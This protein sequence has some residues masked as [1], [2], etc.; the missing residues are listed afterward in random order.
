MTGQGVV[1]PRLYAFSVFA[2]GN[3]AKSFEYPV[4]I[5][6][7]PKPTLGTNLGDFS[8]MVRKKFAGLLKPE[9]IDKG[10]KIDGKTLLKQCRKIV[11]FVI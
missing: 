10:F 8:G 2:G 5:A 6:Q 3:P 9:H 4:E 1:P 11:V 7:T